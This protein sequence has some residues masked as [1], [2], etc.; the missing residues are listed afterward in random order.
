[1]KT[2]VVIFLFFFC[3]L[4]SACS[5]KET[6]NDCSTFSFEDFKADTVLTCTP[7]DFD[8]PVMLPM[9]LAVKDSLL[10]VQNIKTEYLLSVYNLVTKKKI[11]DCMPFGMGPE[12]YLRIKNIQIIDTVLYVY[13][14]QKRTISHYGIH[15]LLHS[16]SPEAFRRI[17]L[18]EHFNQIVSC[19]EQ[20][21]AITMNPTQKRVSIFSDDGEFLQ[22]YGDYPRIHRTLSPVENNQS[23]ISELTYVSGNGNL[24]VFC[25]QTDLIEIYNLD[26][27]LK[28][29]LQGPDLF[30]PHIKEVQL[31]NG[32]SK[33]A[34]EKGKSRDAYFTPL[35]VNDRIYVS[36]SGEY[37]EPGK[38]NYIQNILV[39]DNEG[40][41]LI[42]YRSPKPILRFT[43]CPDTYAIYAICDQPEYHIVKLSTR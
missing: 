3:F 43:V 6:Y 15:H 14:S 33:I 25:M 29:R 2:A 22:T 16:D 8:D 19:G 32:Y 7:V 9:V 27:H 1:M 4:L 38:I 35:T 34:S 41:P 39:F 30:Y 21:A 13:D 26:G 40:N 37:R 42:R 12:E 23:F 20:Y 17:S 36:Y 10:F 31:Q 28:K 24:F 11:K 5:T 18:K